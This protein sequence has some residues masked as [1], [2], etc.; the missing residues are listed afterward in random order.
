MWIIHSISLFFSEEEFA[1]FA[2]EMK[3]YIED[4]M[5]IEIAP[6]AKGYSVNIKDIYTDLTL[7]KIDNHPTGPKR[8]RIERYT[9]IF[10][11]SILSGM[12]DGNE[13]GQSVAQIS[14]QKKRSKK[15]LLKGDP[16][17]GKSSFLKKVAWDWARGTFVTF[18][19]VFFVFLKLVKPGD[20]IENVIIDQNP[21]L[22]GMGLTTKKIEMILK[23]HGSRCLIIL[24]GLDE[25]A[26]GKNQDILKIIRGQKMLNCH[27]LLSSRPHSTKDIEHFFSVIVKVDGFTENQADKFASNV[28][29][30]QAVKPFVLSYVGHF[31]FIDFEGRIPFSK[32]P[33]LLMAL[34]LLINEN[35]I[36]S[37]GEVDTGEIVFRLIRCLYR[38]YTM[39]KGNV[40]NNESF[41]EML[42]KVGCV[43]WKTMLDGNPL[44]ERSTIMREVGEEA[45]DSGLLIG[46]E[47]FR[48]IRDETADI[49]VTFPQRA[50][51]EFLGSFYLIRTLAAG[52]SVENLF[53]K[54]SENPIAI[55]N[56]LFRHF[57]LWIIHTDLFG[58]SFPNK[59][60]AYQKFAEIIVKQ[61]NRVQ[62]DF[63]EIQGVHLDPENK[64]FD[65]DLM[66]DVLGKLNNVRDVVVNDLHADWILRTMQPVLKSL[67][68]ITITATDTH[69]KQIRAPPIS[70]D[71]DLVVFCDESIPEVVNKLHEYS[72]RRPAV[73]LFKSYTNDLSKLLNKN[74]SKFAMISDRYREYWGE[75]ART[76]DIPCCPYLTHL[77][78]SE[79]DS[80][81]ESLLSIIKAMKAG[82]LPRLI[83]LSLARYESELNVIF[84][85]TLPGL[86]QLNLYNCFPDNSYFSHICPEEFAPMLLS[87]TFTCYSYMGYINISSFFQH[88]W[89]ILNSLV[90]AGV[91]S[92]FYKSLVSKINE[93]K[94]VNL[95]TLCIS[96]QNW[97]QRGSIEWFDSSHV[98]H[99][100]Q[101]TLRRLLHDPKEL[102]DL[103]TAISSLTLVKL[104]ISQSTKTTGV[105]RFGRKSKS[106]KSVC[107]ISGGLCGLLHHNFPSLQALVLSDCGLI[108]DDL[109]SLAQAS[110]EV[111]LPELKHLDISENDSV[112]GNLGELFSFNCNWDKLQHL[113]FGS[114]ADKNKGRTSL[115][116]LFIRTQKGSL[117]SLQELE[118]HSDPEMEFDL[119]T[120][121]P[122]CSLKTVRL[123]N[124]G[125]GFAALDSVAKIVDRGLLPGLETIYIYTSVI[126][127]DEGNWRHPHAQFRKWDI[128]IY[129]LDQLL[130]ELYGDMM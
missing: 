41:L 71:D 17:M 48:V 78:F 33:L 2:E 128:A 5:K 39:N 18:T 90:I 46:H 69:H 112:S 49:F 97:K 121:V 26:L 63:K 76:T 94:F 59:Y 125:F 27:I 37:G 21:W 35:E 36:V 58:L 114:H 77:S 43:A 103:M 74:M 61:L 110:A 34:C 65:M 53:G 31:G 12:G 89:I 28:L 24:D 3:P 82:N 105:I 52:E 40:F 7:E 25:H 20:A 79:P 115:Q 93:G 113:S 19:I 109:S 68:S 130:E 23:T 122:W 86:T 85:S 80:R 44:L 118:I 124:P 14:V 60:I 13:C 45:F 120:N 75:T 99:L 50:I 47:D 70:T 127:D 88:S 38:K 126:D 108:A 51:Q 91:D 9:D 67:S 119:T 123:R 62:L 29:K 10:E 129:Y 95:R 104:D 98:L 106:T 56:F 111:R 54:D 30:S 4:G 57:C 64:S 100:E 16:G 87:F 42:R 22:E 101:L 84:H 11:D 83:H 8:H 66:Q 107:S 116:S 32:C 72:G 6:W 1:R 73:Y 55:Q 81:S 117:G 15:I 102:N 92:E 96:C